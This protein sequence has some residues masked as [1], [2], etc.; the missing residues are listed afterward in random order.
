MLLSDKSMTSNGRYRS[1]K[2]RSIFSDV[3]LQKIKPKIKLNASFNL[4]KTPHLLK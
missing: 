2:Y 3:S 1:V 4:P